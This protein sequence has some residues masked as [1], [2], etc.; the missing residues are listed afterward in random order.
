MPKEVLEQTAEVDLSINIDEVLAG[1]DVKIIIETLKSGRGTDLPNITKFENEYNVLKHKIYDPLIRKDKE[2]SDNKGGFKTIPINR[3]SLPL[4]K[5]IVNSRVSFTFGNPVELTAEIEEGQTQETLLLNALKRIN[6]DNK[7]PS[8]NRRLARDT[9]RCTEIAEC[10]YTV[11]TSDGKK[12]NNYGFETDVK[13]RVAAFS[14]WKGTKLYPYFDDLD[15]MIAFSREY[16]KKNA[17]LESETFFEVYTDKKII[18]W[19]ETS[20][21]WQVVKNKVHPYGK[22]PVVYGRQD[23]V[24]WADVQGNIERLETLLSNFAETIDY[25]ASPKV[26]FEGKVESMVQKGDAGG[27]IQGQKGAKAYYLSWAHAPDAVKLEIE[28]SLRFI[29][30]FTSTPDI[31]F[32]SVKGLH[33]I[34]GEAL[35]MLFMD[36]HLMV[37]EKRELWDEYLQRR[38]SIQKAIIGTMNLALKPACESIDIT[39]EIIPF[40]IND[41]TTLI[42]NLM[43]ATGGKRIV[44]QKRAVETLGWAS[45]VQEELDQIEAEDEKADTSDIF[46]STK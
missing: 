24:E 21:G 43:A 28:T 36:A 22:I 11:P 13:V 45:D 29:Y 33:Q 27:L 32:D 35:K 17:K 19:K 39:P 4:Q 26:Y 2:I 25:H 38:V 16:T 14:P 30:S 5:K 42:N 15:N 6:K 23:D 46:E 44:S 9:G 12:H 41:Q 1:D 34:S 37:M 31:S 18:C 7:E 20:E 40:I 8:F 3:V 10:W